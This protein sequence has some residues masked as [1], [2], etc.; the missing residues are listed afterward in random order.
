MSAP[1]HAQIDCYAQ[2]LATLFNDHGVAFAY[3]YGSVARG[4]ANWWSDVDIVISWPSF[5]ETRN[6]EER[7]LMLGNMLG[8]TEK[9]LGLKNLD[10]RVWETLPLR[11]KFKVRKEGILLWDRSPEQTC[12][13]IAR[14]LVE[15]Y[16]HIIWF[17]R[18]IDLRLK[19]TLE[20]DPIAT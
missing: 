10:L 16:D 11:V 9:L 6:V 15:Y 3:L 1:N 12:N 5:N 2:V 20:E 8:K 14:M 18:L 4:E 17:R 19:H 7:I 13:T